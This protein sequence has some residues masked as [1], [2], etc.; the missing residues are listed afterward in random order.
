M[1]NVAFIIFAVFM[2]MII[3]VS[4]S[5]KKD[6]NN[7]PKEIH[8]L[9]FSIPGV[10]LKHDI[11]YSID[12]NIGHIEFVFNKEVDINSIAGNISFSDEQGT[13]DDSIDIDVAGQKM[14]IRFKSDFKL[15]PGWRYNLAISQGFKSITDDNLPSD[16]IID[17]RTKTSPFGLLK[18]KASTNRSLIVCIS[19][20][21]MGLQKAVDSGYCWFSDNKD[22]L[23]QFLDF[24]IDEPH[25]KE[26]V[27]M[28]DLFDEWIVPY[29]ISPFDSAAGITNNREYFEAVAAAE[30]NATIVQKF[31]SIAAGNDILLTYIPGNHDMLLTEDIIKDIIPG[32]QW[33][34]DADGLGKY[35]PAEGMVL[36]HGHRYDFMNCPEPLVND[37]HILPPGFF[38]SRLYAQGTML[39]GPPT[40]SFLQFEESIEFKTAWDIALFELNNVYFNLNTNENANNILMNGVDNY[41][42]P[43]SYNG[44]KEMYASNI[45]DKWTSTQTQN[46]VPVP[47]WIYQAIEASLSLH[48][49]F[50]VA[51]IEY[52]YDSSPKKYKIVAFGHTHKADLKVHK[53]LFKKE[54]TG[55]YANSGTWINKDFVSSDYATRTF[56]VINPGEWSTSE[57]DIVTYYEY[58][59]S[60]TQQGKYVPVRIKEENI[61]K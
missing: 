39:Q 16:T 57:L 40:K 36:E 58:N 3:L 20:L 54:P 43:F 59:L 32:I 46:N 61:L 18:S 28:G 21:H 52:M 7:T 10:E 23:E 26:L 15:K 50:E 11:Y 33:K 8:D 60:T 2:T 31:K 4:P 34:G 27:I 49:L 19:D 42:I 22:A 29:S 51:K 13:L 24:V 45:E 47:L 41:S 37:G 44:A 6:D 14:Y 17:F 35:V 55:I 12:A 56:L 30:T 5:C 1:K 25:V 38:I 48:D 9:T 53:P